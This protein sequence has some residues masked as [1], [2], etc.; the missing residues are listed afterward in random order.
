MKK[1]FFTLLLIAGLFNF[2]SCT[3]D[4][5]ADVTKTSEEHYANDD[6]NTD[7]DDEKPGGD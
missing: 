5:L 6:G 7:P 3:E 1:V 4:S 2:T